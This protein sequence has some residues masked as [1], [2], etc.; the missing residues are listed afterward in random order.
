[1][2]YR[3]KKVPAVQAGGYSAI[4]YAPI[5]LI[6]SLFGLFNMPDKP[7]WLTVLLLLAPIWIAAVTFITVAIFCWVYNFV[8]DRLGGVE[9]EVENKIP[10]DDL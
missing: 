10:M 6:Y 5:G 8:A 9:I 2:I 7:T 4:T 1:M 3:I